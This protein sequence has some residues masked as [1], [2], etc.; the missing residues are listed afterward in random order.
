MLDTALRAGA[1]EP[2]IYLERGVTAPRP[3]TSRAR[4]PTSARRRGA[5][6]PTRCR[7]RTPPAR[8]TTSSASSD[9]ALLY[10]QLLRLAPNRGRPLEDEGAI[11]SM[12]WTTSAAALRCFRRA[13]LLESDPGE[14]AKLEAL[15][16]E[17]G[18]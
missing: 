3:A 16:K 5:L 13:L 18:G 7:W 1:H 4:S 14:R 11:Y 8:P 12:S 17:L 9:A 10:E 6:R 2:E 15:V